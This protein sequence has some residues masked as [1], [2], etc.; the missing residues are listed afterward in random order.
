MDSTP[1]TRRTRTG[2]LFKR[3]NTCLRRR[4]G[5]LRS[6]LASLRALQVGRGLL[7]QACH[8]PSERLCVSSPFPLLGARIH[9]QFPREF[10]LLKLPGSDPERR[11]RG[12]R[13]K[14]ALPRFGVKEGV[15]TCRQ[16][17]WASLVGL[18]S[19]PSSVGASEVT[20]GKLCNLG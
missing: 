18:G 11:F 14:D 10:F 5:G 8:L 2:K 3:R 9:L 19:T 7:G 17:E 6:P 13:A 12:E 15:T 1:N 4:L 20:R 16:G